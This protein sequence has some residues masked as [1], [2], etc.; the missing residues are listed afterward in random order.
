MRHVIRA[1]LLAL[2][3]LAAQQVALAHA[4]SH[5]DAT[6]SQ[7]QGKS[8]LCDLHSAMGAVLGAVH[9]APPPAWLE[10]AVSAQFSLSRTGE[11]G[12]APPTP[13]SRGPPTFP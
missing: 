6:Q 10:E 13:A 3:L 7:E 4:V 12:L 9:A 8:R 5:F 2:A 1:A 11:A